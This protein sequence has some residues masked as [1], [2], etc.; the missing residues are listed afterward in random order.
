MIV[1]V[2]SIKGCIDNYLLTD[3]VHGEGIKDIVG[4]KR[5]TRASAALVGQLVNYH[6]PAEVSGISEPTAKNGSEFSRIWTLSICW[7]PIPAINCSA[8]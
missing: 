8:W 2:F 1:Q 4:F 7:S 6:T 5:L 3:A